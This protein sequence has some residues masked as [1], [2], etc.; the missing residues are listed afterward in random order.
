MRL[1]VALSAQA[2]ENLVLGYRV[3]YGTNARNKD[4]DIKSGS[5]LGVDLAAL[6][7]TPIGYIGPQYIYLNQFNADSYG[8]R[9]GL[10][11]YNGSNEYSSSSGGVAF[12]TLLEPLKAQLHVSYMQTFE[13]KN[14]QSGSVAM[15]RLARKF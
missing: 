3:L 15:V 2:T 4:N 1:S 6:Y 8:P 10:A 13:S 5:F 14:A 11:E 7:R 12:T 9:S